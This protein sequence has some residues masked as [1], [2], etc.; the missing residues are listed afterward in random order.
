MFYREALIKTKTLLTKNRT[1][2][3]FSLTNS[4]KLDQV[5]KKSRV[6]PLDTAKECLVPEYISSML[7]R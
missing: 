6:E 7:S 1:N 5:T 4:P 3:F 2:S